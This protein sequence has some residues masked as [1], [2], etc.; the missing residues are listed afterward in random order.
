MKTTFNKIYSE[1]NIEKFKKSYNNYADFFNP[2]L[3]ESR[4]KNENYYCYLIDC[5]KNKVNTEAQDNIVNITDSKNDV[6]NINRMIF[7]LLYD[8]FK[9][10]EV[11]EKIK[12]IENK[13]LINVY[14]DNEI[15][16]LKY[17]IDYFKNL[18]PYLLSLKLSNPIKANYLKTYLVSQLKDV[19][20]FFGVFNFNVLQSPIGKHL[21]E[22][23]KILDKSIN[24]DDNH[25][26]VSS[27]SN[28]KN[29]HLA[30]ADE[31]EKPKFN[32]KNNFDRVD[33]TIVYEYFYTEL[34]EKK[35]LSK[36]KLEV[37][38]EFAFINNKIIEEKLVFDKIPTDKQKIINVFYKYY[39]IINQDTYGKQDKYIKLLTDCFFPFEY[40]K[41]KNN[42]NK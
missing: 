40:N 31:V 7:R 33:A 3:N 37:F 18:V 42:F 5:Y 4:L 24:I 13:N 25:L 21:K 28:D 29:E 12:T 30:K 9:V 36:E 16:E 11:V 17:S 10:Y 38:L 14:G 23:I 27:V 8:V 19:I 41:V 1:K 26:V 34:V 35:Y 6:N 22:I 39:K 20:N 15:E 32:F 2:V